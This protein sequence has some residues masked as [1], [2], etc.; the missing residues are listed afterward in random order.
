MRGRRRSPT[1]GL[2]NV[3]ARHRKQ[4]L[5]EFL[6]DWQAKHGKITPA[7]LARARAELGYAGVKRR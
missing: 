6:A 2:A 1:T 4:A 3:A 5:A 7:E